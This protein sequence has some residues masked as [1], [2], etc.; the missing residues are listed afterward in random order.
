MVFESMLPHPAPRIGMLGGGFMARTHS[1]AARVA[2]ARLEVLATSRLESAERTVADLGYARAAT[3]EELIAEALP[4]V[5]VCTP[6][7][8]HVDYA[9]AALRAGS[10]VI[11][12]K[13]LATNAADARALADEAT[14]LGRPGAVPFVYRYHPMVQEMRA[15]L[16]SGESGALLTVSGQYLQDWLLAPG[17]DNWRVATS[18]GGPS[19]AF[20]DI[21]SHLVDLI[22]FV[23][24]DRIARLVAA[25][26]TVHAER[27]GRAVETEDAV[28][29]TVELSSGSIGSM[30]VSQVAPGRKNGL[31]L[32][33]AGSAESLRFEQE[34]PERLWVGKREHSLLLRRDPDVQTGEA[35][36]LSTL[37]AGHPQGYQDAFNSFVA[38]AYAVAAGETREGLPTFA[39]GL[40][41]AVITDAVLESARTQAWVE[42]SAA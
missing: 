41:A 1:H 8:S 11:C 34:D 2:G 42:V 10:H 26:R 25:T 21:G 19:R 20:A 15:R 17:D 3:A 30:L 36:R 7:G 6:N 12:E 14:S 29:L 28:A 23:T 27:G 33:I 18:A 31:V 16:A 13:P 38:D 35:A 5:H 32:E 39:D 22:E 4:V 24:G 40:R 9:R 37:P